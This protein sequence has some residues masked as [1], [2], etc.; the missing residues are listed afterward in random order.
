M[1]VIISGS[2][3]GDLVEGFDFYEDQES[4]AGWYFLECIY[5]EMDSLKITGGIHSK[6]FK[7]HH[8]VVCQR[9]PF[10]IFYKLVAGDVVVEAVL[11]S[12]RNPAWIK[13]KLR[14]L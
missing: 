13:R 1:K 7:R 12:R 14:N 8:R 10:G 3:R 11:D 5:A 6:P 9:H 4:G 2:T